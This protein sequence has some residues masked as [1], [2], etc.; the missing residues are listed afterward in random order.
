[1]TEQRRVRQY[2]V[3]YNLMP[4]QP[5]KSNPSFSL[6][7]MSTR[8]LEIAK[9]SLVPDR[10]KELVKLPSIK[11]KSNPEDSNGL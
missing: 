8:T 10:K 4:T 3:N 5:I 2:D 1:M 11:F 9:S 6:D 7:K